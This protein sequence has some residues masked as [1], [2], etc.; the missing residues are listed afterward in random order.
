MRFLPQISRT[1][2]Q[3]GTVNPMRETLKRVI[4]LKKSLLSNVIFAH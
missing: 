2:S 4:P 3:F 1:L